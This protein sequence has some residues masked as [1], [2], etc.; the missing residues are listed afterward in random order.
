MGK[1][2]KATNSKKHGSRYA[3]PDD[4][5]RGPYCA[6]DLTA[7]GSRP[8]LIYFW[9]EILPPPGRHWRVDQATA[10]S[11]DAAGQVIWPANNGRPRRKRYLSDLSDFSQDNVRNQDDSVK[12]EEN[13]FIIFRNAMRAAAE[14]IARAPNSLKNIEWRELEKVLREVLEGL[15]FETRLTRP[16][17]DGGFDLEVKCTEEGRRATYLVEVK[18]WAKP[19]QPGRAIVSRFVDVVVKLSADRGLILSSSGFTADVLHGY[20]EIERQRVRLGDSEKI[21]AL[22]QQYVSRKDGLMISETELPTLLFMST[23]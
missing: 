5:P 12:S 16:G 2:Q 8:N 19:S 18:H 7:P 1:S 6:V 4:D 14:E 13:I 9:K 17:R 11:L 15:G 3:N 22:C 23:V 21:V 10:H 20:S